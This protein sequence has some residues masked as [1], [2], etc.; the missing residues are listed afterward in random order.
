MLARF[1]SLG[2]NCELGLVQRHCGVDQPSLLRFG[3]IPL[4]GLISALECGFD[5]MGNPDR[6][7][8]S[9]NQND[10][11]LCTQT[12][13]DFEIHT[14]QSKDALSAN[15]MRARAARHYTELAGMLLEQIAE[16]GKIFVYR[17]PRAVTP[18]SEADRLHAALAKHGPAILLW[19]TATGDPARIGIAHW[20]SPGRLMVGYLD[21]LAPQRF[22]AGAPYPAWLSLCAA[23]ATLA[24]APAAAPEIPQPAPAA[25]KPAPDLA[26]LPLHDVA[27]PTNLLGRLARRLGVSRR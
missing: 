11:Y 24:D 23:A 25:A 2:I 3:H 9:V 6:L 18:L 27:P 12:D 10:S 26:W 17:T 15:E 1:V 21:R 20:R 13:Y 22:A 19:V 7:T 14:F 8:V 4:E 16:G 5:G